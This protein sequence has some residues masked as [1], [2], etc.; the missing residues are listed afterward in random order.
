MELLGY[1]GASLVG[2]SL[3]LLGGGGAILAVPLFVY[4]FSLP[5]SLAT[6]YSLFVVGVSSL[7]GFVRN[8]RQGQVDLRAGFYFAVPSFL[9]VLLVRRWLLP[10]IPDQWVWGPVLFNKEVVI[11]SSFAV[12][13]VMAALAM[14]LPRASAA[15]DPAAPGVFALKALGVGAVT[16]FVGAGGGFLIVP[17]LVRMSGLG[18]K[19][20][21]GTSLGVIAANSLLG[22][23]GDLW[24]RTPMDFGLLLRVGALA[25]AGIFVGSYWSQHTSEARLKPA[26]GIFVLLLGG[27]IIVQQM[28]N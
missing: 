25:V 26:F 17:S 22:F 13:M 14:L 21:V 2:I 15:K 8:F 6:T 28:L 16:G 24:A 5:P 18:M 23:F 3:G 7:I 10:I 1:F 4:F 19:V 9:G 11:L 12:V 20:A 27:I